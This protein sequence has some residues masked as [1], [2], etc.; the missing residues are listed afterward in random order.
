VKMKKRYRGF[1]MIELLL[2]TSLIALVVGTLVFAQVNLMRDW[3]R[4]MNREQVERET[5]RAMRN[6]RQT[7]IESRTVTVNSAGTLVTFQL[8]ARDL[9]GNY[10]VPLSTETGTARTLQVHWSSGELRLTQDGNTRVLLRSISQTYNGESYRPFTLNQYAPGMAVLHIRLS[11]RREAA[12]PGR[13]IA[14]TWVEE[15]ILLRNIQ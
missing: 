15:T 12:G 14:S 6:A 8:P 5:Q 4:G 7:I 13:P 11:V 3:Q 1:T 10:T 2:S 9:S